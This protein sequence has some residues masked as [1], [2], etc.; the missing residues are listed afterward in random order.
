MATEHKTESEKR[1]KVRAMINDIRDAMFVSRT[2]DGG[3]HGRPM[4][5]AEVDE[6]WE[7]IWFATQGG[8]GKVVEVKDD[9]HVFLGYAK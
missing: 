2:P 7:K 3:L 5:T 6:A 8:T 9:D 4:N 1:A